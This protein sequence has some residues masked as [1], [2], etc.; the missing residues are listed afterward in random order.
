MQQQAVR[1][2][3]A[4]LQQKVERLERDVR[5]LEGM[6]ERV[7]VSAPPVMF[8]MPDGSRR[9]FQPNKPVSLQLLAHMIQVEES[10][11]ERRHESKEER[12]RQFSDLLESARKEALAKGITID[13][14]REAALDD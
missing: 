4:Q 2:E 6:L 8:T 1:S 9:P 12:R 5:L 7:L 3:I 10:S 11:K 13:D 14:E